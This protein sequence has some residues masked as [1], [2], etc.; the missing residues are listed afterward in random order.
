MWFVC[1]ASSVLSGAWTSVVYG[2]MCVE[3]LVCLNCDESVAVTA[4]LSAA[5]V[6]FSFAVVTYEIDVGGYFFAHSNTI[7][8]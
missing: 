5:S 4:Y 3:L 7:T 1:I 8:V 2:T 6:E